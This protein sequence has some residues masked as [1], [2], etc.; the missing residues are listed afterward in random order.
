M[1]SVHSSY[2]WVKSVEKLINPAG[3]FVTQRHLGDS[4]LLK[5]NIIIA[6]LV[7]NRVFWHHFDF[8]LSVASLE[9]F[10]C[11]SQGRSVAIRK[12]YWWHARIGR[13]TWV[14]LALG[15]LFSCWIEVRWLGVLLVAFSSCRMLQSRC[16]LDATCAMVIALVGGHT[17][18]GHYLKHLQEA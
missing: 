12:T 15:M 8:H 9:P 10:R 6:T 7:G 2:F 11:H 13:W 17:K 18:K 16:Q 1:I 5:L 14:D 3:C 4:S